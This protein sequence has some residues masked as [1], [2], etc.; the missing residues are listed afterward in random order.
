MPKRSYRAYTNEQFTTA[1]EESRSW[2]QVISKLGLKAGGGTY[3]HLQNLASKLEVSSD[4]FKGQGWN[5]GKDFKPFSTNRRPIEAYFEGQVIGS[6]QLKL[7]LYSEGYK[8]KQCEECGLTKWNGK[9]APLELDHIDGNRLNNSL[10]NLRILCSNCHALT[11]T[12]CGKNR[13]SMA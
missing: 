11:D 3:V 10:D 1:V 13:G 6:H 5:T 2:S 7:R 8:E 12:Y 4:H 9:P